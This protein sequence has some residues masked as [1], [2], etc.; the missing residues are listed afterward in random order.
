MSKVGWAGYLAA[1]VGNIKE[2]VR[3]VLNEAVQDVIEGAQTPQAP[4]SQTLFH[5]RHSHGRRQCVLATV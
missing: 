4:V 2:D 5:Y 3:Y 1:E